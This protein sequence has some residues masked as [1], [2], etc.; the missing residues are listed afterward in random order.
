MRKGRTRHLP[1][2]FSIIGIVMVIS[3]GY[4]FF[5]SPISKTA[6]QSVQ[7]VWITEPDAEPKAA[8]FFDFSSRG[9]I[10]ANEP[11]H[12]KIAF[13]ITRGLDISDFLPLTVV[14]PD[15][16]AY[17]LEPDPQGVTYSAGEIEIQ[18]AIGEGLARGE[19]Y[20]VFPQSGKFGYILFSKGK[21]V[22][23]TTFEPYFRPVVEV[24]PASVWI[25]MHTTY[26]AL[27]IS[28]MECGVFL[29]IIVFR[30][31]L[32]LIGGRKRLPPHSR[33]GSYAIL[34]I[35]SSFII[36]FAASTFPE[37][38][39]GEAFIFAVG[40]GVVLFVGLLKR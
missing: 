5:S 33:I 26:N 1:I 21:P 15:A 23:V 22:Y 19:S 11:V 20:V 39:D 6:T 18:Q 14:L 12:V 40:T 2:A 7:D 24:E 34:T 27:A 3:A 38:S 36:Y 29:E 9:V 16:Y 28:L 31:Y 17:P 30:R 13:F 4:V 35:L 32:E 25:L 37:I 10:A 8:L